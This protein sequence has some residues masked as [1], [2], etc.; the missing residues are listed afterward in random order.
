MGSFTFILDFSLTVFT[1]LW[2]QVLELKPKVAFLVHKETRSQ[3]TGLYIN[4]I[5]TNGLHNPESAF[6]ENKMGVFSKKK[7]KD[8]K[9]EN[10]FCEREKG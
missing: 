9:N 3:K 7:K 5:I 4:D 6:Q 2:C 1:I 10:A 8:V